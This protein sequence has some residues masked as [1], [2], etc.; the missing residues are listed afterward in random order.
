MEHTS[1]GLSDTLALAHRL[2]LSRWAVSR[3]LNDQPGVS[4]ETRARVRRAA[5]AAGFEPNVHARGLRGTAGPALVLLALPSLRDPSWH[6]LAGG[7]VEGLIIRGL[8]PEWALGIG[9]PTAEDRVWTQAVARRAATLFVLGAAIAPTS[10]DAAG[11][12]A[13][14]ELGRR[15][16]PVIFVEP[17]W[18]EEPD[19]LTVSRSDH[20]AVAALVASHLHAAGHRRIG[21]RGFGPGEL[22]RTQ[23]LHAACVARG[24]SCEDVLATP[25]TLLGPPRPRPGRTSSSRGSGGNPPPPERASSPARRRGRPPATAAAPTALV[26]ADDLTALRVMCE[27]RADGRTVPGDLSLVGHGDEPAGSLSA[28]ALTTVDPQRSQ[29]V[30]RTLDLFDELRRDPGAVQAGSLWI[31]PLLR[32]RGSVANHVAALVTAG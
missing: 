21:L 15:G 20:R 1:E 32:C 6:A 23:A 2:G 27:L 17:T 14:L 3:A 5:A 28:P 26:T 7:L 8:R 31:A 11:H 16:V 18:A 19:G 4:V 25:A 29:L 10:P 24:L 12:A 22:H 13:W 30:A 9:E